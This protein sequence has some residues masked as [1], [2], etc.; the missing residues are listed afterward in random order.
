[1]RDLGGWVGGRWL[2]NTIMI[3][4]SPQVPL[5][6]LSRETNWALRFQVGGWV[7]GAPDNGCD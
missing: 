2:H 5:G 1:M 4:V 6:F 3:T 7:G